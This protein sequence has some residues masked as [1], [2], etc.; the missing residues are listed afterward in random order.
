MDWDQVVADLIRWEGN[1]PNMYLDT[2]G[3]VTVGVGHLIADV[4][5]AQQLGFVNRS[6][7]VKATPAE[8]GDDFENTVRQPAGRRPQYYEQFTK[9]DL[10]AGE[11][12]AILRG[13]IQEADQDLARSFAG[14]GGYPIN[15][16]RALIDM[17]FNLGLRTLSTFERLHHACEAGD[18]N[19]A[20]VESRRFGISDERNEWTR[21]LFLMP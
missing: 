3:Y 21:K 2:V 12:V 10:P 5:A 4:T 20:A 8:I 15:P 9:F 19:T 14:Y 16:R 17:L 11:R 18:W 1:V 13:Q 7:G 6:S